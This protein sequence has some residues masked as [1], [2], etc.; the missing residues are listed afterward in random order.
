MWEDKTYILA[1]VPPIRASSCTS[2]YWDQDKKHV[3]VVVTFFL[4]SFR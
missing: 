4:E 3:N 2:N 1:L